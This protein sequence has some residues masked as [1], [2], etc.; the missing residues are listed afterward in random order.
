MR[1]SLPAAGALVASSFF[2][3]QSLP[4]QS[5]SFGVKAGVPATDAIEGS[6]GSHAEAPR[7][8]VG[9]TLELGLPFSFGVEVDALY[10]RTGYS[11]SDTVFGVTNLTRVRANSWE[12]PILLKYYLPGVPLLRPYISGGYVGR[13]LF[14]VSGQSHSF[15]RDSITGTIIDQTLKLDSRFLVQ[16]DPTH[17]VAIGGGLRLR[18]G[19][20]KLAPEVRYTRWTGRPFED[21]GPRGFFV[22]SPENQVDFLVGLT[23]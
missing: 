10:R 17:G 5:L 7:Y 18:L 20:L 9:P 12:F 2:F 8:T 23:F 13:R 22:Q 11:T 15:G 21:F 14:S 6:F 3:T 16:D 1:L 19:P 4:A